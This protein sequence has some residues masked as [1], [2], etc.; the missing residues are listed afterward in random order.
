MEKFA[1]VYDFIFPDALEKT[2]CSIINCGHENAVS[3]SYDNDGSRRGNYEMAIWQYTLSGQ[4]I[5]R[6]TI[7]GFPVLPKLSTG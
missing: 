7:N 4:G 3:Q 5:F 2:D 6:S 1:D